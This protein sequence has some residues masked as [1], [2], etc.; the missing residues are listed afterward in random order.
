[1]AFVYRITIDRDGINRHGA[2]IDLLEPGGWV[3]EPIQFDRQRG[4]Y[5]ETVASSARLHELYIRDT[6]IRFRAA[7]TVDVSYI[8][9][10]ALERF[11]INTA[12][13][14]PP[15]GWTIEFVR[16]DTDEHF[17]DSGS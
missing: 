10:W 16:E 11:P 8:E 13:L 4:I 6:V 5:V 9:F 12:Q 2:G 3:T 1:M 7:A 15:R 17:T 14:A